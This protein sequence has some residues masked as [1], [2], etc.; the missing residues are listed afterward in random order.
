MIAA[1]MPEQ[2]PVQAQPAP[3]NKR[4]IAQDYLRALGFLPFY[5]I[6]L[7]AIGW[8]GCKLTDDFETTWPVVNMYL[9]G[10]ALVLPVVYLG[11]PVFLRKQGKIGAATMW[12]LFAVMAAW[13]AHWLGRMFFALGLG[14]A[15]PFGL[16]RY[17]DEI[18]LLGIAFVLLSSTLCLQALFSSPSRTSHPV[19]G[20]TKL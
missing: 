10:M 4:D 13:Y 5:L 6:A 18:A 1:S 11:C 15:V 2:N 9:A 7:A 20:G 14:A 3:G 17:D 12:L 19:D 16:P 8:F